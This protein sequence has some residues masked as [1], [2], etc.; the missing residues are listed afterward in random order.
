[1]S[2]L[3]LTRIRINIDIPD[4]APPPVEFMVP[5]AEAIEMTAWNDAPGHSVWRV[6]VGGSM[7]RLVAAIDAYAER[8][9][10]QARW[11]FHRGWVIAP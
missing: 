1:M 2:A 10:G 5:L 4:A 7:V 3:T 11:D 9:G 8:L 6:P